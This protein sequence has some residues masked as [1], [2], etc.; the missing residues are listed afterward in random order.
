MNYFIAGIIGAII[1]VAT[2]VISQMLLDKQQSHRLALALAAISAV[3]TLIAIQGKYFSSNSGSNNN[4]GTTGTQSS[5]PPQNA[6]TPSSPSYSSQSS[7]S[8]PPASSVLK[9][10]TAIIGLADKN[11]YDLDSLEPAQDQNSADLELVWNLFNVTLNPVNAMWLGL[12]DD[13][14][15]TYVG[16]SREQDRESTVMV[17]DTGGQVLKDNAR[18]CVL[19]SDDHLA[20]L[21]VIGQSGS[22]GDSSARVTFKVIVW[23]GSGS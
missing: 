19:T 17:A 21:T 23:Y 7:P 9:E 6:N 15:A 3:I 4:G 22:T 20:S 5:P 8:S 10:G 13:V 2:N 12:G 11:G 18:L 16:C 1:G 14:P